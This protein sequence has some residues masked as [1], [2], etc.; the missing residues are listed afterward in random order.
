MRLHDMRHTHAT[1]ML[2]EGVNPKTVAERLGHASVV[3]TL[4]TY[5]HVLPGL[6]EEA[7][8]KFEE[9]MR[10]AANTN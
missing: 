10:K 9:G 5:S 2:K 6:Q 3:I 8:A 4:D 1:L 7:A